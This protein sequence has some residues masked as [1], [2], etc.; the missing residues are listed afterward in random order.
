MAL[1]LGL[2]IVHLA[3]S[4][5]ARL[6]ETEVR[7]A[8]RADGLVAMRVADH[9]LRRELR[10][11]TFGRDWAVD[12]DSLALR[13]FRGTA[14][15]CPY[16]S[17]TSELTVSYDGDRRPDPAKDSVLLLTALGGVEVRALVG[18][19]AAS[20][21]CGSVSAEALRMWTLDSPTG[22]GI[23]VARLF[24]RG[25]Y[26]LALSALRYR[27]GSS[28]RQ[29]LTPE[30]WAEGT[31]WSASGGRLGLEV[32]PESTDVGAPWSTFLAWRDPE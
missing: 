16:E 29:P 11:A 22:P 23:V 28:G 30:V 32:L 10:H 9:V 8:A 7:L 15:V 19:A 25:S 14:L 18:S 1:L 3:L 5:L 17:A 4:T 20:L 21:P 12:A 27:R 24:E 13:A 31:A 6:R 2:F 26:H